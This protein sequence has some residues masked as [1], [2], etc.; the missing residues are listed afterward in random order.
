[1]DALA[2]GGLVA[3]LLRDEQLWSRA[4]PFLYVGAVAITA[5]AA[6]TIVEYKGLWP[7]D[8]WTQII[9]YSAIAAG[10]AVLVAQAATATPGSSFATVL[11][12][13]VLRS[14]GRYSYALYV[15][16]W[17]VVVELARRWTP[18]EWLGTDLPER[19]L[20]TTVAGVISFSLAWMSWHV[21]EKRFLALKRYVPYGHR[22]E[23]M[24]AVP[25]RF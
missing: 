18:R 9:G 20:F 8:R 11:S 7:Y 10:F 5:V 12:H 22:D 23:A 25:G 4:R 14:L 13:P 24:V 17:L 21:L 16:H 2:L 19:L 6:G 3:L 1:M 15:L